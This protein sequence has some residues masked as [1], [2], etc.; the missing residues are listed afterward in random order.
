MSYKT[1]QAFSDVLQAKLKVMNG[2]LVIGEQ[3]MPRVFGDL[4]IPMTVSVLSSY[5]IEDERM[6]LVVRLRYD[7][8]IMIYG[9]PDLMIASILDLALLPKG[10]GGLLED[11][12]P[13]HM[14][15]VLQLIA[16]AEKA[17]FK[18][19]SREFGEWQRVDLRPA[20]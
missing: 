7:L 17:R 14:M 2:V 19:A 11:G 15:D 10:G 16:P 20:A 6:A 12:R 9:V 5:R 3:P 1:V 4:T 18:L 13:K 8:G